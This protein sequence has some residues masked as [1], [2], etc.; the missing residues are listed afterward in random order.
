MTDRELFL[1]Q[2]KDSPE[3]LYYYAKD[4]IGGRWPEAEPTI[5]IDPYCAYLYSR[6]VIGGRW[7]EGEPTIMKDPHYAYHY[8]RDIIKGRWPEAEPHIMKNFYCWKL[9]KDHFKF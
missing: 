8:A 7:P 2:H 5:M 4:I 6:I 1:E 9:Y 3:D